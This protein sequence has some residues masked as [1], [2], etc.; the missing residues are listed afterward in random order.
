MNY[1]NK[2]YLYATGDALLKVKLQMAIDKF[3][4]NSLLT[5]YN[6]S[7]ALISIEKTYCKIEF[8]GVRVDDKWYEL[9]LEE[10]KQIPIFGKNYNYCIKYIDYKLKQKPINTSFW[11]KMIGMSCNVI[12]I[13]KIHMKKIMK[14]G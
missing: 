6:I 2:H 9:L 1:Q 5:N 10:L 8:R 12:Q 13:I 14:N 3:N 7:K 11:V 4:K